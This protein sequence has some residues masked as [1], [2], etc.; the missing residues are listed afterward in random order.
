MMLTGLVGKVC[1]LRQGRAADEPDRC[2]QEMLHH[3]AVSRLP[4]RV[5]LSD[6]RL[7]PEQGLRHPVGG[8]RTEL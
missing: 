3:V 2:E 5:L 8:Q 4:A 6:A 1:G 7:F